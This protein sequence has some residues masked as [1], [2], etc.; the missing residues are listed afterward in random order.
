MMV[1]GKGGKAKALM[2]NYILQAWLMTC[3]FEI[4][5]T[6]TIIYDPKHRE[7]LV[8]IYWTCEL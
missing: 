8:V 2:D 6:Y 5:H 4:R 7:I 3:F 1:L